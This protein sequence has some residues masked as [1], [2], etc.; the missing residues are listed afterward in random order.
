VIVRSTVALGHGLGLQ[1]IGEGIEQPAQ[2]ALLREM[3]CDFGQGFLFGRPKPPAEL[4]A[5]LGSWSCEE[6]AAVS[7]GAPA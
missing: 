4:A 5:V 2:A 7:R 6:V 3:G 1:V